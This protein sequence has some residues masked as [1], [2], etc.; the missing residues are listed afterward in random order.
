[1]SEVPAEVLPPH[2]R[3]LGAVLAVPL[4]WITS[5]PPPCGAVA[6]LAASGSSRMTRPGDRLGP[7]QRRQRLVPVMRVVPVRLRL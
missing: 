7:G 4:S 3:G 1:M 2:V 6:G 5:T